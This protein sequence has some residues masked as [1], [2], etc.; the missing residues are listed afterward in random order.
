MSL[1]ENKVAPLAAPACRDEAGLQKPVTSVWGVGDERAK[2]LARLE[3]FTVEDLLLHKPRRYEDR[4]KF[5]PIRELKI[6]EAAT[7][8]GKIIAS[9][10][11]RW[12]KGARAM[13]EFVL[14]DGT[15]HLH[16]RWWQAQPWMS[17]WFAVGREF[18][19]FGK[20]DSLKPR[21]IDHP[22][23]E[24]VEP[25]EDEFVHVNR[26]RNREGE[27]SSPPPPVVGSHSVW[28]Q[29]APWRRWL[30]ALG[31]LLSE[32]NRFSCGLSKC[33]EADLATGEFESTS[34]HL[35]DAP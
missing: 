34:A 30:A 12:K 2:L 10:V 28:R 16:C 33:D 6:K 26:L 11:K 20:P 9:G 7:V 15:S 21:N 27:N 29:G 1:P 19:V 8:R 25:G 4:R 23:T 13:F 18:L 35:E 14:D 32:R 17:D 5:L 22:E 31:Q 24:L 3:I